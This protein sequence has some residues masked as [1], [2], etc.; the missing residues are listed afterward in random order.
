MA[1]HHA[2]EVGL[3]L[4]LLGEELG[5]GVVGREGVAVEVVADVDPKVA[6][7]GDPSGFALNLVFTGLALALVW[8]Y[9]AETRGRDLR[10]FEA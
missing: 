1:F 4:G 2:L 6:D 8:R 3:Q 5:P 9:G 10:D 7:A